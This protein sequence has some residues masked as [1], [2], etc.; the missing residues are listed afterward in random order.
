MRNSAWWPYRFQC[1]VKFQSVQHSIPLHARRYIP[2]WSSRTNGGNH[3]SCVL[4]K[5]IKNYINFFNFFSSD[6]G[7]RVTFCRCHLW[8]IIPRAWKRERRLRR[9]RPSTH[10]TDQ[11]S[12][13]GSDR[14]SFTRN[15]R[16]GDAARY[17]VADARGFARTNLGVIT[18]RRP[19]RPAAR[20]S[21]YSYHSLP[22]FLSSS[23]SFPPRLSLFCAFT[24]S[25]SVSPE[26][27]YRRAPAHLR[28]L[29][30]ISSSSRISV[31]KLPRLPIFTLINQ[32]RPHKSVKNSSFVC[33][34]KLGNHQKCVAP[35]INFYYFLKLMVVNLVSRIHFN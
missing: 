16:E 2:R 33:P 8:A 11:R 12:Y 9:P 31:T 28:Q 23:P 26:A 24:L 19:R 10:A 6:G 22:S 15:R 4:F 30:D 25:P 18:K 29:I 14:R 5:L 17:T 1:Q 3:F 7:F 32:G 13:N 21:C 27:G 34:L 20:P 35:K